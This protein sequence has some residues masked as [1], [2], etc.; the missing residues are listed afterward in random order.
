MY[1]GILLKI[2]V[3]EENFWVELFL[4]NVNGLLGIKLNDNELYDIFV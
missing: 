1:L 3:K 4:E 2:N